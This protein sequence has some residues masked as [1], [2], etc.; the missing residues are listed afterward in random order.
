M[1]RSLPRTLSHR[2]AGDR[3]VA[4]DRTERGI[5]PW[6]RTPPTSAP[7]PT[8]NAGSWS[9][10]SAAGRV[11]GSGTFFRWAGLV[12]NHPC[13]S[14][15]PVLSSVTM[16]PVVVAVP[17]VGRAWVV[18]LLAVPV[19]LTSAC[20]E[21]SSG[22]PPTA[23]QESSTSASAPAGSQKTAT[24]PGMAGRL[25]FGKAGGVY[26]DGTFFVMDADGTGEQAIEGADRTCCGRVSH[27]ESMLLF[28]GFT[29]DDRI[30]VATEPFEGG[31]PRLLPLP[32]STLNLGPGAWS[33]D[34]KRI[35][36]QGWDGTDPSKDGLYLVD[37]D[38]GG[39]RVRLTHEADGRNHLPGDF[40][41]DGRWL[42]FNNENT[43]MQS[44]GNLEIMD[45]SKGGVPRPLTTTDDVGV[46]AI[47]FSPD[48]RRI[49]FADGRLSP[50]ALCG[51]SAPTGPASPRC[52]TTT[53]RSRLTRPGRPTANRSCS[54]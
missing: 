29:D 22:Q 20:S 31:T 34:G 16:K 35:A 42:A 19:V 43:T 4:A 32:G 30:T 12:T 11:R 13:V 53:P 1:P 27:D 28:A 47:R 41:P 50:V 8:N 46:G 10:V 45:V 38:D 26:E 44:Q 39:H 49:L 2:P 25:V 5:A 15:P 54:P 17:F 36:V 7:D 48:G 18:A 33:P 40:S 23:S 51:P 14:Y 24:V 52:G 9:V 37:S 6:Q 21:E 3:H